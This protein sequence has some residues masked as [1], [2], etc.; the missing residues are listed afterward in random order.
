MAGSPRTLVLGFIDVRR[1]SPEVFRAGYLLT[2]DYG[3]PVEFH[4]TSAVQV[5]TIHQALYGADF[6]PI[7]FSEHLSKPM[8]DRQTAA[9]QLI[10]VANRSLLRLRT[11]I[12]APVVHLSRSSDDGSLLVTTHPDFAKDKGVFEKVAGLVPPGFDWLELFDRLQT[13]LAETKELPTPLL[14]A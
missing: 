9:P 4:Y 7:F 13:A 14:V 8:T 6:E 5:S 10:A 1:E 3:R 2:T 12:P 11:L